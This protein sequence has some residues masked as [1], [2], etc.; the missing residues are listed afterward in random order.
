MIFNNKKIP[1]NKMTFNKRLE[2]QKSKIKSKHCINYTN[3][4]I[5]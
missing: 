1:T 2:I 4:I 3:K 5:N